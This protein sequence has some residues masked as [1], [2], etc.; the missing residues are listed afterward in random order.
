MEF[1]SVDD[2]LRKAAG[3]KKNERDFISDEIQPMLS[4]PS[5]VGVPP[6]LCK[7]IEDLLETYG[8]EAVKQIGMFCI[9]KWMSIHNDI[10]KQHV[11]N[12]DMAAALMTMNDVSKLSTVLQ[13][14]ESVGSFGGDEE[15]RAMLK[16]LVGQAVMETCEEKGI[17]IFSFFNKND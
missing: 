9:G 10:L 7:V 14:T 12:E 1:S 4:D 17:D 3:A 8:D 6:K 5:T 15:W 11:Q 13:V 16:K 2:F